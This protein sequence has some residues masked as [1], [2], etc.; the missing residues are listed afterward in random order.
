MMSGPMMM[1]R[2]K[3]LIGAS[4][5]FGLLLL[6]VGAVLVDMSHAVVPPSPPEPADQAAARA[7]LGLVWGPAVAHAGM[8]FF[9]VGLIGA[10]LMMDE[11]D[12]FMR[13]FL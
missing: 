9:V 4:I 6:F 11:G 3:M 8:F 10:A 2:K 13:L 12:P 1:D 5:V 7:N